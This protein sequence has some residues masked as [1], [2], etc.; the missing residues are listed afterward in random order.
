[1]PLAVIAAAA[2]AV[3]VAAVVIVVAHY[4][5][6]FTIFSGAIIILLQVIRFAVE[7]VVG[8]YKSR[9]VVSDC[10]I[11]N[12]LILRKT[13]DLSNAICVLVFIYI[14]IKTSSSPIMPSYFFAYAKTSV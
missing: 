8:W 9:Q 1:M 10:S 7:K 13:K 4:I 12:Y 6:P 5:Q 3:A 14:Y 11:T 2:V